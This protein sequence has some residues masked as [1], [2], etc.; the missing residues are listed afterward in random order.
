MPV[1]LGPDRVALDDRI[2]QVGLQ[3][4]HAGEDL[5]PVATHL[6]GTAEG[7]LRMRRRLADEVR[8]EYVHEG[9]EIVLV[10]R[11]TESGHHRQHRVRRLLE[12]PSLRSYYRQTACL[13]VILAV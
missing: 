12:H 3:I 5:L 2:Q 7:T 9:L 4:R 1:P 8:I 6:V 11:I 10:H 13:V